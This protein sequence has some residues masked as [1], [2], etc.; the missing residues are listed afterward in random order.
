MELSGVTVLEPMIL[1]E[2][3]SVEAVD[4]D[5]EVGVPLHPA[6]KETNSSVT[7][8]GINH[9]FLEVCKLFSPL[10]FLL[11]SFRWLRSASVH[12]LLEYKEDFNGALTHC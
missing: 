6:R 4:V 1:K 11:F 12:L 8:R 3:D 10:L 5:V 9:I 2:P 7:A